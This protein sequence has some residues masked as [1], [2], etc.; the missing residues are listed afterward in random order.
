MFKS[1]GSSVKSL[2]VCD[3]IRQENN[4]KLLFIGVYTETITIPSKARFPLFLPLSIFMQL[5]DA[6]SAGKA[7]KFQ[8]FPPDQKQA[9]IETVFETNS[10]GTSPVVIMKFREF[11]FPVEGNY[12]IRVQL[13]GRTV[14]ETPLAVGRL[15][16]QAA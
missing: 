13:E 15:P 16:D 14:Y 9:M 4:G 3:D 2:I 8:I 7:G 1:I 11:V 6:N 12:R 10:D 5:D